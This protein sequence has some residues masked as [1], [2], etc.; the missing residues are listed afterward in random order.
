MSASLD[1]RQFLEAAAVSGLALGVAGQSPAA[2]TKV[3]EKLGVGV[4]GTGGRGTGLAKAYEGLADTEV[5]YVCDVDKKRA[6]K[7]AG[8]VNKVKSRSPK[9]ITDFRKMLDDKSVDAVVI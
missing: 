4:V 8:E 2:D 9:A 7:A 6:E 3:G 5:A 1:R